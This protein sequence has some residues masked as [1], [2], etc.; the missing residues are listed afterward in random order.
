M[1]SR[2]DLH[3]NDPHTYVVTAYDRLGRKRGQRLRTNFQ[4]SINFARRWQRCTGGSAV[5]HRC[6]YNTSLPRPSMPARLQ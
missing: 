5:I 1:T 6:L 3:K 4:D 2:S